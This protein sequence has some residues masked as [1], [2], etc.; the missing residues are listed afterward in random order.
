[1]PNRTKKLDAILKFGMMVGQNPWFAFLI[2]FLVGQIDRVN[3]VRDLS[4]AEIAIR[5]SA[6]QTAIWPRDPFKATVRGVNMPNTYTLVRAICSESTPICVSLDFDHAE[7]TPWYQEVL[8]PSASYAKDAVTAA[9]EESEALWK[10]MDRTL[11]VYREC[12][13]LLKEQSPERRRELEFYMRTAE[14]EMKKISREL[15]ELNRQ[16]KRVTGEDSA[17]DPT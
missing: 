1:M 8:L 10:E 16:M 15:E 3:F 17:A 11:D 9:Q 5:L 2:G 6:R 4:D 14:A 7:E 12:R 13:R